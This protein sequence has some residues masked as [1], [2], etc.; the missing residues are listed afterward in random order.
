V[1]WDDPAFRVTWPLPISTIADKDNRWPDFQPDFQI[2]FQP[3]HS[4][5]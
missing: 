2:A 4:A 3:E 1:R 5:S